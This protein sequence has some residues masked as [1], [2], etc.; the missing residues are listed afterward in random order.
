MALNKLD[1][2]LEPR[3]SS[4]MHIA[5]YFAASYVLIYILSLYSKCPVVILDQVDIFC[6]HSLGL[7]VSRGLNSFL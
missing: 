7:E 1:K 2:N 6:M 3:E 5:L 4:T